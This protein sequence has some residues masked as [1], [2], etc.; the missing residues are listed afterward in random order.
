MTPR[1]RSKVKFGLVYKITLLVIALVAIMMGVVSYFS[2][3]QEERVKTREMDQRMTDTANMITALK[4]IEPLAGEKVPW[5]IFREFVKVVRNL[6]P[7]ILYIAIV[8][9][10]GETKAFAVNP[11][12]ARALDP[13]LEGLGEAE[14]ALEQLTRHEF[15]PG[16]TARISGDIVVDN[17]RVATVNIRFSLLRLRRELMLAKVRNIL[18]TLGMMILGFFGAVGVAKNVTKPVKSLTGAMARV[19]KGDLGVTAQATS[20][21]EIG[22]LTESFNLMVADLKEKVRIKDAFDVVA[23][24]LKDVEKVKEAF[25]LY[26]AKEAQERYVDTNALALEA[27]GGTKQPVTLLFADMTQ[28]AQSATSQ[29]AAGLARVLETYFRK[30]MA[31]VFEY[32]GQVYKFSEDV[33]MVAFG[34]P[35]PHADDDR[36]AVLAAVQ[37]QKALAG[38]NKERVARQETPLYIC[39]GVASGETLGTLLTPKGTAGV[40]V[41]RDYLSFTLRMS[42]QPLSMVMVDGNVYAKVTNLVRGEKIEDLQMPDSGEMLEVY[43][44]TGTKF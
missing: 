35:K 8:T 39:L 1:P 20:R 34:V 16:T 13:S 24:E 23:D 12:T 10:G 29:E 32:E 22:M 31:T 30:F 11:A 27:G 17:R 7:N 42:N 14:E 9:E 15:P 36:R 28:L 33:F 37:M 38:L 19:A 6:D 18:L 43:R 4:L 3:I 25:Q 26:I 21:D 2:I 40:E 5:S 44:I 41:I